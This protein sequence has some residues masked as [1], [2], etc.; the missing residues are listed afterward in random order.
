MKHNKLS[1]IT[2]GS[3]MNILPDSSDDPHPRRSSSCFPPPA[4]VSTCGT[5]H[6][7]R[8]NGDSSWLIEC[9][10]PANTEENKK[11]SNNKEVKMEGSTMVCRIVIDPWL[12]ASPGVDGCAC[13]SST[14]PALPSVGVDDIVSRTA[15]NT[16]STNSNYLTIE[17][18]PCAKNAN[19]TDDH[20]YDDNDGEIRNTNTAAST[21]DAIV[22]S[23]PFSDHCHEDT[24]DTFP[25]SIPIIAANGSY[26]RLKAYYGESRNIIELPSSDCD[27]QGSGA[28]IHIPGGSSF[29]IVAVQSKLGSLLD[30]THRGI[31]ITHSL[32]SSARVCKVEAF[33][34]HEDRSEEE[35][36]SR[37]VTPSLVIN[38]QH[39]QMDESSQRQD[40][41]DTLGHLLY[42]PHGL[43]LSHTQKSRILSLAPNHL[44]LLSTTTLYELPLIL[45]GTVNLGIENVSE[46]IRDLNVIDF[47]PTHSSSS[48]HRRQSGMVSKIA[49]MDAVDVESEEILQRLGKGVMRIAKKPTSC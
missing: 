2:T 46:L 29:E 40:N 39:P 9:F 15:D 33:H 32:N 44:C 37:S 20:N 11:E 21:L 19:A 18:T 28:C 7:T 49:K 36:N 1:N 35:C 47:I 3:T 48:G 24:L 25:P 5:F 27:Y 38:H 26:K 4:C 31:L 6:F 30:P 22:I 42:A 17:R 43:R 8:L 34:V 45:G 23:L 12:E 10:A 41:N 16:S 14:F 13:F